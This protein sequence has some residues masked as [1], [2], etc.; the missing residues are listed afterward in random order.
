M[1]DFTS[2]LS[3]TAPVPKL[4]PQQNLALV[5][6]Q[7]YITIVCSSSAT[8]CSLFLCTADPPQVTTHPKALK[9][10]VPGQPATFTVHATGT[11]PLSYQWRWT[12]IGSGGE[13]EEEEWQRCDLKRSDSRTL[14]ISNAKKSN[15]GSYRCV[16]SNV[17]G[18]HNSE[19]ATLS[20]G[21]NPISKLFADARN[22][23]CTLLSP[24]VAEP[25][26]ITIHPQDFKDVAP[27]K[28]VN[29]TIGTTGTEPL[30][31]QWQWNPAGENGGS[32]EWQLCDVEGSQTATL[33]I[34]SAQKSNEGKYCCIISN[35]AGILTSNTSTLSLGKKVS[36]LQETS[37]ISSF[38]I[39]LYSCGSH[40]YQS[41]TRATGCSSRG[42]CCA[43][44]PSNWNRTSDVL[45]AVDTCWGWK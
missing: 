30:S 32:E 28:L 13:S 12:L 17:A 4:P 23:S 21:K 14:T 5:R 37:F 42:F 29:F 8:F 31:Y 44:H 10:V 1:R 33:S 43:H 26:T 38:S 22:Q 9:N 34:P 36:D 6:I 16:I 7:I 40:D 2:V 41:S 20:V 24:S 39:Y 11:E 27:G 15:E 35:C 25:P 45:L 19:P 18:S 3:A